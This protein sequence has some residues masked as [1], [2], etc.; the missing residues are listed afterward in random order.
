MQK[1]FSSFSL[2][3]PFPS[4]LQTPTDPPPHTHPFPFPS[5]FFFFSKGPS[6][7]S[8]KRPQP[9]FFRFSPRESRQRRKRAK[10]KCPAVVVSTN[11]EGLS[12]LTQFNQIWLSLFCRAR[13]PNFL[14]SPGRS[15]FLD[16]KIMDQKRRKKGRRPFLHFFPL[17]KMLFGK[18]GG[19]ARKK[20]LLLFLL[21]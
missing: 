18:T 20:A 5:S 6:A 16:W 11:N 12:S 21:S 15:N 2:L 3:L 4:R 13:S 1:F 10:G 19:T 8:Y 7:T 17:A 14:S 9:S